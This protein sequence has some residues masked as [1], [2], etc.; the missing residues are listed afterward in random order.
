MLQPKTNL[1]AK[2]VCLGT[3]AMASTNSMGALEEIVVTAQKRAESIN[4]VGLSISAVSGQKMAEQ[5]LTSLEEISSAVPGLVYSTSTANTPIFT[6]RGIGFNEQSLGAYPATSLYLDEAPMPF[7]ALASHAAYDLERMEVLK[8]P[9]GI[10]FGQNSTGGAI[11]FIAAKPGDEFEA[12]IDVSY[13]RF[14][15]KEL[16]GFVSGPL[17]DEVGAR[18]AV[19]S[20]KSDDWQ[21]SVSRGD[22]NGEEDYTAARLI[23][24]FE[25]TD[26]ASYL[27]NING[28][29][30]KSDPI[31]QQFAAKNPQIILDPTLFVPTTLQPLLDEPFVKEDNRAADWSPLITPK[32]DREYMQMIL[33]GDWEL[34]DSMTLTALTTYQDFEQSQTTDGD[35]SPL[36]SFDLQDSAAE[37]DTW[38]TEIRLASQTDN[39]NWVI[40]ANY[41]KSNTYEDQVLRYI[42]NTNYTRANAFIH[43]SG[44]INDQEIENWAV[45]ANVDLALTELMTLKLGAR[46]TD[47][48]IDV[49]SCNYAAPN[50]PGSID[51]GQGANVATLFNILGDLFNGGDGDFTNG[52]A[53]PFDIIGGYPD[54]YT[55]NDNNVPGDLYKDSLEEDNVSWR[56]GLDYDLTDNSLVYA[57]ISQG[58][59][60]GSFP[61][62][63]ASSFQQFQPVTQESV[64]AYELGIKATL[65]DNTV[66]LNAALFHYQYEDKQLRTKLVEPT[67]G[68]LD[69]LANVPETEITGIEADIVWQATE[70]LTLSA[71]VTYLDSEVT[72]YEGVSI[73]SEIAPIGPNGSLV[74]VGGPEDFSGDPIPFTPDLT[75]SLDADY[76]IPMDDGGEIFMG[77]NVSGQSESDAAFGGN[78]LS[79]TANQI[80]RGADA[81]TPKI[82]LMESYAIW[83][84]RIGY[85][86]ADGHWNAMLW[87]KNLSDEYYI[88]NVVA[89]SDST[90]RIAGRPRTYGVTVGYKF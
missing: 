78:R 48:T 74:L 72:D 62:L 61:S 66:Q 7:P 21:K 24:T 32:S 46:Y 88:T 6:L 26:S 36:I 56:V 29:S 59:K 11:N 22:E 73:S 3:L 63:A 17:S 64:L 40:G 52:L 83:G 15:K 38:I 67:F 57:N 50:L 81:I 82:N 31:A 85:E 65:A 69:I 75:Y 71:A 43:G 1:L 19:T 13:G 80:A 44:I 2:A 87:G 37:I 90:S 8:G 53:V 33:R 45:F 51:A 5:K 41:E 70:Q 30:D 84:A 77:V 20:V 42:D 68:F 28:W 23:V 12:G 10:L 58:Y 14:A 25:P 39:M 16:N 79:Y 34:N 47:S 9:Q 27:V 86:S 4:D 18:L 76:R 54:C 55:L 60:S 35:G 49:E 89:S